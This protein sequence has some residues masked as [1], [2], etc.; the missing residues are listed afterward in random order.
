MSKVKIETQDD[1][2]V[3]R[4][5]NGNTNAINPELIH[6]MKISLKEVKNEFRGMVLAGNKHFF[7][8]GFDVPTLLKL[9]RSGMENFFNDF[10]QLAL[11]LFTLPI[12]TACAIAGH[13]IGGGNI[14]ALTQDYRF[15]VQ[16]KKLI[17]L[18]EIQL[19][20]PVPYLADLILRHIIGHS[21]AKDM[22]YSGMLMPAKD[23]KKIGVID[24]IIL[25]EDVEKRAIEKI[26][27][28]AKFPPKGF[29]AVKQNH[30]DIV[31]TVYQADF[32]QKN[33]QFVDYW[34]SPEVQELLIQ[35]AEKF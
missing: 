26:S 1:I 34:F 19:G 22:I 9:D 35:A 27:K 6:D 2:A 17:G 15:M 29:A 32:V 31:Q 12:P 3:M 18:N 24:E 16:E 30:T 23:A 11:D 5:M 28:I 33:R 21:A 10:N 13:A 8:I 20:I 7:A 4:M 14:L 25:D